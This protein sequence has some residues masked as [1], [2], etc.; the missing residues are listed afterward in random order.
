MS[1]TWDAR[2]ATVRP[3]SGQ[4][5]ATLLSTGGPQAYFL[6]E[7]AVAVRTAST[8]VYT[9]S[10]VG[11]PGALDA[12]I[13][14]PT[15]T[16]P[17]LDNDHHLTIIDHVQGR[18]HDFWH[19]T[20]SGGKLTGWAAGCS[21][22]IGATNEPFPVPGKSHT[23]S[24]AACFPLSVGAV[25]AAEVAA[26]VI[27]HAL[28]FSCNRPGPAPNPYPAAPK[29]AGYPNPGHAPLGSWFRMSPTAQL[30][31]AASKLE[32]VLF[33]ALQRYGMFLRDQGSTLAISGSDIGGGGQG[34]HAWAA[35]GV[36]LDPSRGN[37]APRLTHL[38]WDHLQALEPPT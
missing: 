18:V 7:V 13:R 1:W 25:S 16:L 37:V 8:P 27:P 28:H 31:A 9:L 19:T 35:A 5:I 21:F 30:P 14:V 20:A 11:K 23:S 26:G 29:S 15:G 32:R 33:A 3:N 34:N 10:T 4:L 24:N 17:G 12:T 36:T 38:P 2:A 6:A 22:P